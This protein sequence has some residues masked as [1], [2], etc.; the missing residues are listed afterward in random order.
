[1]TTSLHSR[2]VLARRVAAACGTGVLLLGAAACGSSSPQ[3][4]ASGANNAG[5]GSGQQAGGAGQFPGA[6]GLVAAVSGTTAQVQSPQSGQV[7][8]SWTSSTTFTKQVSAKLADVKVGDCVV[9]MPAPSA[10]GSSTTP[11]A[12]PTSITAAS[13]RITTPVG[14]SCTPT[15]RAGGGGFGGTPPGGSGNGPQS[16]GTPPSGTGRGQVRFGGLGAFGKVTAVA[17]NGFTVV[18]TRPAAASGTATTT[19][20]E[21]RTTATTTFTTTATGSASDVKVGVCV[22][23]QGKTDSTG[24]I[25]AT[26]MALTPPVGGQ[27]GSTF[28][29]AGGN[30]AGFGGGPGA[31]GASLDSNGGQSS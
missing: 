7:A 15:T 12:P 19:S 6:N 23:A 25:T 1:M 18:Q 10:S 11:A 22:R 29:R 14:G 26:T 3:P 27:C 16:N 21:V 4:A 20:V 24:A 30:G 28:T 13:V 2:I 9:A 5:A 31:G 17:A 8:V